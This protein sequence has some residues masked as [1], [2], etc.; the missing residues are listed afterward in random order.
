MILKITLIAMLIHIIARVMAK[1]ILRKLHSRKGRFLVPSQ[2]SIDEVNFINY[3]LSPVLII[4]GLLSLSGIAHFII[5][6]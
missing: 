2:E 4:T 5:N 1:G 6:L 3:I